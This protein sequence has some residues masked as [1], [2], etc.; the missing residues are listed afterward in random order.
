APRAGGVGHG[1]AVEA[2]E[3]RSLLSTLM[4]TN[5]SDTGG[6][7]DGSLRGEIGAGQSGDQIVFASGLAGRTITLRATKGPLVLNKNLT[8]Q[9]PGAAQL[10]ISGNDATEVFHIAAG[11]SDTIA[12]L[13]IARG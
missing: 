3:T 12:G 7:G 1:P 13:T 5:V 9:G 10:T 2:L 8:I 11:A 6:T 4:V